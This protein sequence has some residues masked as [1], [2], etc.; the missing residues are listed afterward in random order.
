MKKKSRTWCWIALLF[1]GVIIAYFIIVRPFWKPSILPHTRISQLTGNDAVTDSTSYD[2]KGTDLGIVVKYGTEFRYIFGDTFGGDWGNGNSDTHWRSNVM[3]NSTDTNAEDGIYINGWIDNGVTEF[4][5]E[6][7]GSQKVDNLEMTCIPTTA[8]TDGTNFYI[9]YMSVKH[10]GTAGKWE[11]NNASIASSSNGANFTKVPSVKWEGGSNQVMF[12]VVQN[13]TGGGL[14]V[15]DLYFLTTPAGRSGSAYC[16]KVVKS[17]ILNQAAYQCFTNNASDGTPVWG[18]DPSLARAVIPGPVGELSA[19]WNPYLQK[20]IVMYT[21]SHWNMIVIRIADHPWGPWSNPVGIVDSQEYP[22]RY[23][24]FLHPDLVENNGR[25]VYFIMSIWSS[26]NT[27]VM[28]VDLSSL[29]SISQANSGD[30]LLLPACLLVIGAFPR[31]HRLF[32]TQAHTARL[33]KAH[34]SL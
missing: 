20:F 6:L 33:K 5:R 28:K 11:C 8:V 19:M 14:A 17:Q 2:V 9:Y 1:A 4:A 22:G 24:S 30:I 27:F 3:A 21:E 31:S 26:Y 7:I 12:G 18:S 13:T 29:M 32:F 25:S 34:S 10:W 23:G 16:V 15:N